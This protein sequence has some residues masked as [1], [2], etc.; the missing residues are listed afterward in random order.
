MAVFTGAVGLF[1]TSG[2]GETPIEVLRHV[3]A[4]W[5]LAGTI[6][7]PHLGSLAVWNDYALM[8]LTVFD[9]HHWD[10]PYKKVATT[11]TTISAAFRKAVL[12]IPQLPQ[13]P[14]CFSEAA[15]VK[16]ERYTPQ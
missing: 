12:Q 3:A 9:W 11:L 15:T 13:L 2:Y 6:P 8:G 10:G 14:V 16:I 1:T 4:H 7:L 5:A